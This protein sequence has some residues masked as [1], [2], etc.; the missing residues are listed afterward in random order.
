MCGR[1]KH[2]YPQFEPHGW[3][4]HYTGR[5]TRSGISPVYMWCLPCPDDDRYGMI[6][7][8]TPKSMMLPVT[9]NKHKQKIQIIF[10]QLMQLN[11]WFQWQCFLPMMPFIYLFFSEVNQLIDLINVCQL[12][13]SNI[14]FTSRNVSSYI[15][16][17][18][19]KKNYE[20]Q[21]RTYV[22]RWY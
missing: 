20:F 2:E 6:V 18:H 16:T 9:T 8:V 15:F 19:T 4:R 7:W 5:Y 12:W 14:I 17:L 3:R 22:A 13:N 11:Y 1:Q 10:D 21:S